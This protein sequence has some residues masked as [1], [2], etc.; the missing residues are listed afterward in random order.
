MQRLCD[1][2]LVHLG[3]VGV[4]RV[5]QVRT[6]LD[7]PAEHLESALSI[8]GPAADAGP[9][10]PHAA[11]AE[12]VH[13]ELAADQEGAHRA[14]A[15]GCTAVKVDEIAPGLWRWTALHPDW[16]EKDESWE[17][18]VGCTFFEADDAIVL[19]DPLVPDGEDRDRFL[20]HLDADV[21]RSGKPVAILLTVHWHA[22]SAAE[23]AE[24]YDAEIWA[25]EATA[26]HLDAPP[27]RPFSPGEPLP[28]EVVAIDA[29]RSGE[30]LLWIARHSTLVAGDVIL[31]S[32]EGGLRICPASWLP[33]G[34]NLAQYR[35]D[36]SALLDLPI[37]RVL[38]SHGEAILED[39]LAALEAALAP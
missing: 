18:E 31:G 10:E 17:Q 19:I 26:E 2:E 28:G 16:T 11:V 29:R 7:G 14:H 12:A 13:L 20:E 3:P 9:A 15:I 36:L 22:R 33:D 1:L 34:T 23:L 35:A 8:L 39:G 6:Q 21:E 38:V 5:D 24:R 32:D 37:E 25:T 4:G 27:N 30:V